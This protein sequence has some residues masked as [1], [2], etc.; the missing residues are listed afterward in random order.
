MRVYMKIKAE[1]ARQAWAKAK[2]EGKKL[3][4]AVVIAEFL[5]AGAYSGLEHTGLLAELRKDNTI[6][7]VQAKAIERIPEQ[8]E[9]RIETLAVYIWNKEST[10]GKNNYSKCEAIGKI[11]GIGYGIPGN[12]NYICFASHE[13]EMLVLEGWLTEKIARGY[14][15]RETLCLYNTGKH[16][17]CNYAEEL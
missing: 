1:Q 2:A 7:V 13:E 12:G 11:N 6:T 5:I 16:S 4:V 3:A 9:N 8:K 15:E 14:S 17:P 10:K